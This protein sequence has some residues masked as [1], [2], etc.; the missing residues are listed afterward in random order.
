MRMPPVFRPGHIARL[1]ARREEG[2]LSVET[3][4]I[5]PLL[6]MVYVGSFVWF[7]AFR[8][9][10]VNLKATYTIADMISRET[11]G[12][13]QT[14]F[15]GLDDVYDYL[16]YGN[17]PTQLRI[18]IIECTAN[19]DDEDTRNLDVCW[20]KSTDGRVV[21][22]KAALMQRK[23][24]VPLFPKGDE[25]IVAETFMSYNPAFEVGLG[26]QVFENAI[27]TSPRMPGQMKF[28]SGNSEQH[29]YNN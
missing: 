26:H 18:S 23:D 20:S 9:Q 25:L 4:I 12:I 24:T 6:C 3:A 27:F 13:T 14:Y 17:H 19:C 8:M 2:S 1:F 15:D 29:C 5:L 22:D 7:D 21:L 28:I 16:T 10:N 11:E